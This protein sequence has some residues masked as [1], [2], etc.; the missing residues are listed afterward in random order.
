[1]TDPAADI[2]ADTVQLDR[3]SEWLSLHVEG[4]HPPLSVERFPGGQSNPTYKL[5]TPRKTYVMRA[6]PP[7]S[8]MHGAHAVDREHRVITSL[9]GT[10]VPVPITYALCE[11]DAVIGRSFFVMDYVS[12]LIHVQADLPDV[13]REARAAHFDAMN[14]TLANLHQID[15]VAVGL[16]DFGK[17]GGY[18]ERQIRRW[19]RQYDADPAAGR[20]KTM[21]RLGPWLLANVP[22]DDEVA[23]VHGDF[24]SHNLIFRPDR[25]ELAAVLDWELSTLGH[26][27]TDFAFNLMM[28]RVPN[29]IEGW[30]EGG[31][32]KGLDL[33][34]LNIP[35]E[36]DYVAAY[37]RRTGRRTIPHLQFHLA[38]NLYRFA[39]IIHGIKGRALRGNASSAQ[40]KKVAGS[41][42]I[43]VDLAWDEACLAG[44]K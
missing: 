30:V 35:T 34:A 11:D 6:Q 20:L 2:S 3:L 32:L 36:V 44:M 23:I 9:S 28:Y 24:R 22:D 26:P 39:T 16:S 18:L 19:I 17:R 25:P 29:R 38:Y 15:P 10:E 42:E 33:A 21:D 43:F 40:A 13:S 12:G 4:F 41:L 31:G 14:A 5:T 8:L 27:I 7:G 37:C 1:M